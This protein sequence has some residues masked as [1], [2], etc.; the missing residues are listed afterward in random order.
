MIPSV[1]PTAA[2]LALIAVAAP[3]CFSQVNPDLQTYFKEYIGL[4]DGQIAAIRGGQ[5]TAK[6]LQS[7]TPDEVFVFGAIYI[8]AAPENYLKFSRDFDRLR[9]LPGYLAIG[10][11]S[12]PPQL[13]DLRDFKFD[14]Q[15]IEALKNCKPAECQI[16]MPT[17][18]IEE[19]H[20]SVDLSAPD[21][22]QQVSKSTPPEDGA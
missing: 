2:L 5:A 9:K 14:S 17:S 8:H 4:D 18:S 19:L 1:V 16:Q 22:E 10:E 21:A 13:S 11:F 3:P 7:R 12:S 15:D 6:A 20:R